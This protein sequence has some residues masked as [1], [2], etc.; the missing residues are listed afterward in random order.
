MAHIP[1][2]T[3]TAPTEEIPEANI[4]DASGLPDDEYT[5]R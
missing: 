2:T 4:S 3:W 5:A 1:S